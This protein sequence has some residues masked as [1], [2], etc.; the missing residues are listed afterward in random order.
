MQLVA[1]GSYG[2]VV[3]WNDSNDREERA[4]WLPAFLAAAGVV[5]RDVASEGNFDL[6]GGAMAVELAAGEVGVAL[7]DTVVDG[8]V[9]G[10]HYEH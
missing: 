6:L 7:L 3:L 8:G 2:D 4:L 5:V 9:D 10:R 1:V